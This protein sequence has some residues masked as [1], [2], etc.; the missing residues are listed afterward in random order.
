MKGT[1]SHHHHPHAACCMEKTVMVSIHLYFIFSHFKLFSP[2][3]FQLNCFLV[4]CAATLPQSIKET[5]ACHHHPHVACC[6]RKPATASFPLVFNFPLC[7]NFSHSISYGWIV[8]QSAASAALPQS[9]KGATACRH[10]PW[11]WVVWMWWWCIFLLFAFF[12]TVHFFLT[13]SFP[14]KLL[15]SSGCFL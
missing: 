11:W 3:F 15:F 6:V 4:S 13:A 9:I 1:W 14:V 2:H 12:P 8:L 7:S 10:H 5:S